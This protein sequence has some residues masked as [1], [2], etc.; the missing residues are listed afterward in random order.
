LSDGILILPYEFTYAMM[1]LMAA[2]LS[3]SIVRIN[4]NF[5]Y[6]FYVVTKEQVSKSM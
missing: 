6:Y 4:I 3:F 1:G 2:L 5:A